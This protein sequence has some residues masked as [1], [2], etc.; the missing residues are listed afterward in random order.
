MAQSE[1]GLAGSYMVLTMLIMAVMS[2]GS[3]EVMAI[4]S[5]IVYDIYQTHI[6]PFKRTYGTGHCILCGEVKAKELNSDQ[7]EKDHEEPS[8]PKVC[9]CP[10]VSDCPRCY[11][12]LRRISNNA[13]TNKQRVYSCSYHGDYRS[14]LDQLVTFKSWCILWVTI[15]LVPVGLV[16]D[17]SGVDLN[18]VMVCGFILTTP[19]FPPALMAIIWTKTSG[20]GVIVGS[21]VGL[22]GGITANF[23]A[24][25]RMAKRVA[26]IGG[27]ISLLLFIVVIP[28]TMASLHV[29]SESEFR[30]WVVILQLRT[31]MKTG[32][33]SKQGNSHSSDVKRGSDV[34]ADDGAGV[35]LVSINSEPV[36]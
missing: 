15:A 8:R 33:R 22:V 25:F 18:Y 31:N 20:L 6:R 36:G 14:Y 7:E 23:I 11:D 19:S 24:V 12:D 16:I 2:S 1:M 17:V 34:I 10:L 28:G 35:N 29:L 3:G 26:Y 4:S 32:V 30:T 9:Q 21:I 27:A 5:I 13:G